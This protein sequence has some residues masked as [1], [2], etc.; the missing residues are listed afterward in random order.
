MSKRKRSLYF[1][2]RKRWRK[3][4]PVVEV[5]LDAATTAEFYAA[6]VA[7]DSD[8]RTDNLDTMMEAAMAGGPL[9]PRTAQS[10]LLEAADIVGG[11]RER[12]HGKKERSFEVIAQF[13]N[14]YLSGRAEPSFA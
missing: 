2:D 3:E 6:A 12:T 13:W 4:H 11:D 7:G 10:L 14:V 5:S 8:W 1:T 9:P